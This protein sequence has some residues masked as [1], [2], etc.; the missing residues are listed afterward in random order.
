MIALFVGI[1]LVL[2][3]VPL[4]A[5]KL[6]EPRRRRVVVLLAITSAAVGWT[7]L[8]YTVWGPTYAGFE[9]ALDST[10]QTS[11][12]ATSAT[13]QDLGLDSQLAAV[14][15]A[16]AL[17]FATL[18]VGGLAHIGGRGFGRW[19]MLA[20]LVVPLAVAALSWGIA[21]LVPAVV[22]AVAATRLAF[23]SADPAAR[24]AA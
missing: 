23:N 1:L 11:Q 19:L 9:F 2:I 3:A 7:A 22:L 21:G 15:V 10:G 8:A 6:S 17:S 13:L 20:S 4:L 14:M 12:R 24:P 16:L 5:G 18:V